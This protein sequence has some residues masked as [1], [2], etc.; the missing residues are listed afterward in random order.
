MSKNQICSLNF[1][2]AANLGACRKN[3]IKFKRHNIGFCRVN[4]KKIFFFGKQWW[5]LMLST[6]ACIHG[7]HQPDGSGAI[8]VTS[9]RL[10]GTRNSNRRH[11]VKVSNAFISLD[12]FIFLITSHYTFS[13]NTIYHSSDKTDHIW[14]FH[15]LPTCSDSDCC[16][17]RLFGNYN[18]FILRLIL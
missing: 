16:W 4:V 13:T 10:F 11:R 18:E 2:C 14:S 9:N 6:A 3:N 7:W 15:F 12:Y 17:R 8:R 1:L 5:L